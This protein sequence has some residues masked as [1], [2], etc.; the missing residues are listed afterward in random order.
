MKTNVN[1]KI[2]LIGAVTL[3]TSRA[4]TEGEVTYQQTDPTRPDLIQKLNENKKIEKTRPEKMHP[5]SLHPPPDGTELIQISVF[6]TTYLLHY[7]R[8]YYY[9]S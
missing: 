4:R 8:I 5:S 2:D 1:K 3:V 7:V 6:P 9:Y